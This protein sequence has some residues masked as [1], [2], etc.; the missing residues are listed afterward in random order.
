M[1][2]RLCEPGGMGVFVFANKETAGWEAMLS[3][4]IHSGWII[5]A[6]WPI[7]TEMGRLRAQNSA[8]SPP[9]SISSA[10]REEIPTARCVPT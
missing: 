4:L 1:T 6:S 10:A 2:W 7:D 5:T 3:A 9:L 8:R